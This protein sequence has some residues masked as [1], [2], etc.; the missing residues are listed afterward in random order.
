MNNGKK[1]NQ[2]VIKFCSNHFEVTTRYVRECL[3]NL[4]KKSDLAKDIRELYE[5]HT[6]I[7]NETLNI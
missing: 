4:D 1:Y 3:R 5:N 7:I 6:K 2:E